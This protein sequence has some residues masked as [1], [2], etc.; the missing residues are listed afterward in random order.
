MRENLDKSGNLIQCYAS[1]HCCVPGAL[2]RTACG[3]GMLP[4][5]KEKQ[6]EKSCDA[7]RRKKFAVPRKEKARK[8]EGLPQNGIMVER[9]R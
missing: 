2:T 7:E 1:S 5:Q 9:S 3:H 4:I 8:G 6:S